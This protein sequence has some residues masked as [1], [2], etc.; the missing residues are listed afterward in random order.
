MFGHSHERLNNALKRQ[1]E[2]LEHVI[3]A[4]F[5]HE[6]VL[7]LLYMLRKIVPKPLTKVFFADGG[8]IVVEVA[9]KMSF[10]YFKNNGEIRNRFVCLDSGYHGETLGALSI[11]GEKL[12]GD[13]YKEIKIDNIK[14]KGHDCFRCT[15]KKEWDSCNA[16]CFEFMEQAPLQHRSEVKCKF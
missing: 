4:N 7:E 10:G 12:Y 5:V 15:Y 16:E 6:P 2:K 9:M 3:F 1:A 14:V 8:S 11:F 13:M